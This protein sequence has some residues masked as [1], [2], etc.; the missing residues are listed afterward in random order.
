VK[1]QTRR[2]TRKEIVGEKLCAASG[3]S[4]NII[5]KL[6]DHKVGNSLSDINHTEQ[7]QL[8]KKPF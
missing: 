2:K 7:G 5:S 4:A 8:F 3:S 1:G 6:H